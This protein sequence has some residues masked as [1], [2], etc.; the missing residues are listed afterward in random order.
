MA[1]GH[2][3]GCSGLLT[4]KNSS[5]LQN[6]QSARRVSRRRKTS[7]DS[8]IVLENISQQT[9]PSLCTGKEILTC[10]NEPQLLTMTSRK[11][12]WIQS[13]RLSQRFDLLLAPRVLH[14][15]SLSQLSTEKVSCLTK[16][17]TNLH[18]LSV[19]LSF[20]KREKSTK[21][22]LRKRKSN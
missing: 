14:H 3:N 17:S 1:Y 6:C 13:R 7:I 9:K 10:R 22:T 11:H 19:L 2:L 18:L 21:R 16:R 4:C 5:L 20:S 12:L 8:I 15:A